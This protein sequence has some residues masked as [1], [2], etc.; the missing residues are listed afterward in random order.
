M[1]QINYAEIARL[2]R[3][4]RKAEQRGKAARGCVEAMAVAVLLL[5]FRSWTFMLGV[6]VVHNDWWPTVPPI[7]FAAS[8]LVIVLVVNTQAWRTATAKAGAS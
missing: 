2:V 4:G 5:A 3:L 8:V 7:G 1:S 6:G